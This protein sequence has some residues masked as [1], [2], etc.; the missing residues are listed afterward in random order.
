VLNYLYMRT[1]VPATS[2]IALLPLNF[3]V[4][5]FTD[6]IKL[7]YKI[8]FFIFRTTVHLFGYKSLFKTFFKPW[9]NEYRQGMVGFSRIIGMAIKTML[10]FTESF[11]VL[12]L[13]FTLGAVFISWILLPFIVIWGIYAGFFA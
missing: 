9:K 8:L 10:I 12:F 6:N 3:I 13:V 5:W 11:F 1:A 2:Y 4:W 7:I